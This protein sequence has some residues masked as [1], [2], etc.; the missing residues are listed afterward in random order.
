[1]NIVICVIAYNRIDSLTRCLASLEKAN[2]SQQVK[3]YLSVDKSDTDKIEQFAVRYSWNY[4]DKE[5]IL[6]D[7][8]LGLRKHVLSCGDLL[9]KHDALIV[10]E[11][12]IVV[13]PDFFSYALQTVETFK[14]D[15]RIAG[16]SLYNFSINY[17]SHQPF[18]PLPSNSDVYLMQNASSWGQIWMK[19]QWFEFKRWYEGHCE[20]FEEMLHLPKSICS[21]P[22]S[23]WLKYHTRYCIEE[24][25]YFV[26]P[27]HAHSTCF[28]DAGVHTLENS[29]LFQTPLIA[30][31]EQIDL[32][33]T[34]TV[35]YDSYFENTAIYE[36]LNIPKEDICIDYYGDNGNREGKRYWLS[37]KQLPYKIIQSFGLVMRPYELNVKYNIPGND[38]FLY[39]TTEVRKVAIDD[40]IKDRQFFFMYRFNRVTPQKVFNAYFGKWTQFINWEMKIIS[41]IRK[42]KHYVS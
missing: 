14:H 9:K 27:Y 8:N 10:L 18:T 30:D 24:D 5:V 33:L 13:S 34:P 41:I 23:S 16:I 3:L 26:Y 29:P 35:V 38:L 42:I 6:H 25:K 7:E 4:G 20:D 15:K 21:W 17:H 31:S 39:E 28:A 22:N 19:D 2:Y 12:D 11:D 36:W 40:T 1:M 32:R 37:R